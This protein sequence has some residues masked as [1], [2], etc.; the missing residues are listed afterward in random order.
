MG[1]SVQ[2]SFTPRGFDLSALIL[3]ELNPCD[4]SCLAWLGRDFPG[5]FSSLPGSNEGLNPGSGGLFG[6]SRG[7]FGRLLS[8]EKRKGLSGQRRQHERDHVVE[9]LVPRLFAQE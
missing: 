6:G 5:A 9:P 4:K 7:H 3:V 1:L 8:A 2:P